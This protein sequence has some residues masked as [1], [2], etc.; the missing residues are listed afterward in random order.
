ME[1]ELYQKVR[2]LIV[3]YEVGV[4]LISVWDLSGL[5]MS[6]LE[7]IGL[8]SHS[9]SAMTTAT[10]TTVFNHPL[11]LAAMGTGGEVCFSSLYPP[12]PSPTPTNSDACLLSVYCLSIVCPSRK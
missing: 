10:T 4:V 3:Q 6:P 5:A 11:L 8:I 9:D 2:L 1:E 7:D 12:T